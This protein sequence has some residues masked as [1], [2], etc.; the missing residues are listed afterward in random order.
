[1]KIVYVAMICMDVE[2]VLPMGELEH[3]QDILLHQV[4]FDCWRCP[5]V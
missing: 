2:L 1:M 5:D 4:Q 3:W